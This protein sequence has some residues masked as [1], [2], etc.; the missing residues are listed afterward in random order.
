MKHKSI[1]SEQLPFGV[2]R[3]ILSFLLVTLAWQPARAQISSSD[4]LAGRSG[5]L[6]FDPARPVAG[7]EIEVKYRPAHIFQGTSRLHLRARLRT[8]NNGSYNRNMGSRQVAVLQRERDGLFHGSFSLPDDVVYAAFAVE[9]ISAT[10]SDSR[11]GRFWELMVH[12]DG[13]PIFEALEQ[14]FNDHMGR[15]RMEVLETARSMVRT[16]PDRIQSWSSLRF[17]E[18]LVLS[19]EEAEA[20]LDVHRKKLRSFDRVLREQHESSADQVGYMYWYSRTLDQ[21]DLMADWREVLLQEHPEHFFAV[22]ERYGTLRSD[23][24]NDWTTILKELEALWDEGDSFEVRR[25]IVRWALSASQA[26]SD[27]KSILLWADRSVDLNE[28]SPSG[29]AA[30]LSRIDTTR[31]EGIRRLQAEISRV[32]RVP[33]HERTLGATSEK[34]RTDTAM[35]AAYLRTQLAQ[36]LLATHRIHEAIEVLEVVPDAWRNVHGYSATLGD[37]YIAAGDSVGR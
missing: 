20:R 1:H 4:T 3:S 37:A 17:A 21:Q 26:A 18:R 35:R 33:D 7:Q 19:P 22:Q 27:A 15:D 34:Y 2:L 30:M 28:L 5:E 13:I 24:G 29:A 6:Q 11:H 23:L 36:A 9:D 32:E 14:R 25:R 16:Y 10:R 8:P 31:E 12:E